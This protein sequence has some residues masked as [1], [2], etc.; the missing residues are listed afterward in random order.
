MNLLHK[1]FKINPSQQET[2]IFAPISG[3]IHNIKKVPDEVFSKKIIGD[4]IAIEPSG[5]KIV[6]PVQGIIGTIFKTMHAFSIVTKNKIEIF[7]H[8]GIDTILLKGKGFQKIA[9]ENQKVNV[10]DTI[11]KYDLDF[12]TKKAKSIITPII[13]SNV[14]HNKIIKKY[15]G[16]A[17]EGKTI[18]MKVT[19]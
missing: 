12:L 19:K 4:G 17:I 3:T 15:E 9:Q 18:I 16:Q 10:G 6:A 13:I 1:I 14:K 2:N 5:N 11:I 8:F 7:V